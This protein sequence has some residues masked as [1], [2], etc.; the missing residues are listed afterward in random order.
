MKNAILLSVI[1]LLFS[2]VPKAHALVRE[3]AKCT[4]SDGQ[5]NIVVMDNQGIGPVR[6]SRIGAT[7]TRADGSLVAT[8]PVELFKGPH[9]ISFGRPH[10]LD[11]PTQGKLFLLSGPSTN[12]RHYSV[13]AQSDDALISDDDLS[14]TVFLGRTL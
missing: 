9:S 14:C 4:T 12:F 6:T 3:L 10:F 11:I 5:Y 8:Y 1:A 2:F 13:R 7:I